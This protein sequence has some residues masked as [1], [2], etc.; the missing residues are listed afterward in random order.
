MT[1]ILCAYYNREIA[2]VQ[3]KLNAVEIRFGNQETDSQS[4]TGV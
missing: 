3:A 4:N 1:D 2:M